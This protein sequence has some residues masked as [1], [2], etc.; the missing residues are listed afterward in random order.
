MMLVTPLQL[1]NSMCI[2]ANKGYFYLPHFVKEIDGEEAADTLLRPF[3]VKHEVLTRIPDEAYEA[4]IR[5]MQDVVESGT[6]RGAMIPG[7]EICAKTGTAEKYRI[8]DKKRVKLKDNSVFV[9]FAPR[10]NPKIA[11]AVVVE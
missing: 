8:I 11:I 2:I 3:R 9:C 7:L 4:A 10:E 1:A 6:G 5:G